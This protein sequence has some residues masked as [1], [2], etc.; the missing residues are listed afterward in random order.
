MS[1]PS[2]LRLP[3]VLACSAAVLAA[4]G[5]IEV[6]DPGADRVRAQL[7][8]LEADPALAGRAPEA[9]KDAQDAVQAAGVPQ[10]DAALSE[11]LVYLADRKVQIARA[12]AEARAA[13]DRIDA[14]RERQGAA[15]A[16]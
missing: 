3:A 12:L 8:A 6:R 11:H 13:E 7:S 4:C 16:R 14:L 5:Y 1:K 15:P 2:S 9:L 10:R